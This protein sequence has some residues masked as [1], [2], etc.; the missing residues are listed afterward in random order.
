MRITRVAASRTRGGES[1]LWDPSAGVLYYIDNFGQK[2]H[3]FDPEAKTTSSWDMPSIV[4]ALALGEGGDAV[5]ALR[6]GVHRLDFE[7]GTLECLVPL[8]GNAL[9]VYNDGRVDR[10]GRFL[11][12]GTT[13]NFHQPTP[14]GGIYSLGPD[15]RLRLLDTGIHYS[16]SPCFSPDDRTFYFSDSFLYATYAYDYDIHT[17]EIANKRVF[18]NTRD[19]GGMPD[20]STVDRDGLVWMA[21]YGGGKV[22]AIDPAGKLVRSIE[23][24]V[25]LVSSVM[26]GGPQLDRLYVTTIEEGALGEPSEEGA[27]YVYVVEGLDA[28]GLPESRY[29]G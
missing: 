27:G 24:P 4:T 16:N 12:G 18:V 13:A 7:S 28:R 14:D 2:V 26:F 8:D 15:H 22:V 5:V 29:V 10:R 23:F 17:G 11:L 6:S 21:I 9:H 19:L 20:G 1:P 3:R 25:K